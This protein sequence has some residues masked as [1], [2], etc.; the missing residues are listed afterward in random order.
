MP[1]EELQK[2]NLAVHE[3]LKTNSFLFVR[4][5][6]LQH[7]KLL[8]ITCTLQGNGNAV[9]FIKF[10]AGIPETKSLREGAAVVA[11][12]K[13]WNISHHLAGINLKDQ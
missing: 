8:F 11:T 9:F 12:D 13:N 7:R 1:H 6:N 5:S 3:L 2:E 4:R 10:L